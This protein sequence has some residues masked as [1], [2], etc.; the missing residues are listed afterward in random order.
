MSPLRALIPLLFLPAGLGLL[1]QGFHLTLVADR[2]LALALAL[3]C[4]ELARMARV[5]LENIAA[6]IQSPA[7]SPAE[8]R[9]SHFHRV[10]VSTIVLEM[11]GFYTALVSLPWGAITIIFSQLWF[12]LL[13]GIQLRPE[14]TPTIVP[15]GISDRCTVLIANGL[16]L[17]LLSCWPISSVRIWLASGVFVLIVLFLFIKYLTKYGELGPQPD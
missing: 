6:I 1:I 5:D 3:F 11:V 4:P 13:A 2:I 17:A 7:Q 8:D 9:L 16:G 12:N 10:A 15:L 14:A